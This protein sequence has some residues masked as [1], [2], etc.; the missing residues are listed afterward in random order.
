M[1]RVSTHSAV[2]SVREDWMN[3]I[4]PNDPV[5]LGV[6]RVNP[7]DSTIAP[8]LV[9]ISGSN[10]LTGFMN[11]VQYGMS[12]IANGIDHLLFLLTLLLPAP[13]IATLGRWGGY[14]GIRPAL[15]KIVK[16]TTAFTIGHSFTLIL[17]SI[18]HIQLPQ[19]PIEVLIA[20]SILVSAIHV[21]RPIFPK[22]EMYIAGGFGL[23]HGMAFS[24]TLSHLQLSPGQM[25]VSLFGFNAGIEIMQLFIIVLTMPFFLMLARTTTYSIF[26]LVI[27]AIAAIA[28]LSW[29]GERLGYAN[30]LADL[31]SALNSYGLWVAGALATSAI[32][33]IFLAYGSKKATLISPT[34]DL[35]EQLHILSLIRRRH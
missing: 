3:G 7:K 21:L 32:I 22:R 20:L 28:A 2:V 10:L 33:W 17:G 9:D 4:V 1:H 31:L 13:L 30:P 15:S 16:I 23:V 29:L 34:V 6:I 5:E 12:H 27:G 19:Q 24:F 14:A 8:L 25:A 11:M 18:M 35:L 26:R